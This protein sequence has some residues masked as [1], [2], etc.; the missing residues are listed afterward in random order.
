MTDIFQLIDDGDFFSLAFLMLFLGIVGGRFVD[1]KPALQA[2]GKRLAGAAFICYVLH[3]ALTSRPD[4]ASDC[5]GVVVRAMF[6]ACLVLG[7]AWV[8]LGSIEF[9]Y[10]YVLVIPVKTLRDARRK[11]ERRRFDR[12]RALQRRGEEYGGS[13]ED[14]ARRAQEQERAC[15]EA[16][17]RRQCEQARMDCELL[18]LALR[19]V[20][21]DQFGRDD[22]QDFFGSY[23]ADSQPADFIQESA[24]RLKKTLRSLYRK[25]NPQRKFRSMQDLVE[26]FEHVKSEVAELHLTDTNMREYFVYEIEEMMMSHLEELIKKMDW[27]KTGRRNRERD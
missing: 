2:W 9:V 20:I 23:M 24:I 19:P 15:S 16:E 14:A 11:A 27:P 25:A 13:Y 4:S 22:L 3:S 10:R 1:G 12:E 21:E 7:A 5:L 8:F 17:A 18:W 6:A 26:R